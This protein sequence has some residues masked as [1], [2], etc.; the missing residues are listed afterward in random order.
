MTTGLLQGNIGAIIILWL[1]GIVGIPANI[2]V[3]YSS[4]HENIS[5]HRNSIRINKVHTF[6]ITNLAIADL[7]GCIYLVIIAI[8]DHHYA[9]NYAELYSCDFRNSCYNRTNIWV[10]SQTCS[11]ARFIGNMATIMPAPI[12]FMISIDRYNK[13][14]KRSDDN[15]WRLTLYR[16]KVLILFSWLVSVSIAIISNIRSKELYDPHN[17]RSFTNTCYF[18]D[19]YD[20][21]FQIFVIAGFGMVIC[22]YAITLVF[23]ILIIIYIHRARRKVTSSSRTFAILKRAETHLGVVT[24][25]LAITNLLSWLPALI[26]FVNNISSSQ[27][28]SSRAGYHISIVGFLILFANSSTNPISYTLLLSKRFKSCSRRNYATVHIY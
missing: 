15:P 2:Y 16:V 17:F 3:I 20:A 11:L 22:L 24:G 4:I 27:L 25:I 19:F 7:L 8:A 14:I 23:Y 1:F 21:A 13:I 26:F 10:K 9:S 6:L 28:I 12:T 5:K 18:N